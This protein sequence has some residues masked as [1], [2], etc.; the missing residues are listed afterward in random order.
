MNVHGSKHAGG[1]FISYCRL[2]SIAECGP[3]RSQN[4]S[5]FITPFVTGLKVHIK[6]AYVTENNAIKFLG[7]VTANEP[8]VTNST[9]NCVTKRKTRGPP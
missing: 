8:E 1:Q 2:V 4:I 5:P 7:S 9:V 6:F 3:T